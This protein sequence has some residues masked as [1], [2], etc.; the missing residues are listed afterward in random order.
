[1]RASIRRQADY[2]GVARVFGEIAGNSVGTSYS[3]RRGLAAAQIHKPLQHGISGA[4]A[5]GADSIVVS[6]GYEDDEDYGTLIV[7]T[8]AGGRDPTTGK[9][10]ADQ[11]FTAQNLALV[12]SEAEGFEVRVVRG[13]GGEPA[14]SPASGFR[15]DGLFRVE[16]SWRERGKS[17][18]FVC[19]YRL[20]QLTH[21]GTPLPAPTLPAGPAPRA[22]ATVQRIVRNTEVSRR[23]KKLHDWTCQICG[24]RIAIA[25]GAYAEGAHI[26]PLGRPH[27]GPDVEG[28]V[29]CLCPNDHVRLEYGALV[30]ADDLSVVDTRTRVSVGKLRTLLAHRIDPAHLRYHRER[31]DLKVS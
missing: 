27:D 18:F 16:E 4:G 14:F 20:V 28:N 15:Y 22:K 8:G 9:Q 13:S 31:F 24:T 12:K 21:D 26:R 23:V 6:G 2:V 3:D 29:L 19:R 30:I 11:E 25:P 17:G 5:E 7:Y 10:I 1:L